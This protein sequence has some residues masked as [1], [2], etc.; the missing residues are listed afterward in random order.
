MSCGDD[1]ADEVL[2]TG[3][4]VGLEQLGDRLHH[5][6]GLGELALGELD[7]H[8]RADRIAHRRR[9]DLRAV[10]GDDAARLELRQ[11]RLD[12]PARDAELARDLEQADAREAAQCRDEPSVEPING[13]ID[14]SC[15]AAARQVLTLIDP[16]H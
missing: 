16:L 4:R 2:R 8:E 15:T 5:R 9:V 6:D 10:A 14:Q 1:A 7:E 3:D 13:H 11:P 12:G